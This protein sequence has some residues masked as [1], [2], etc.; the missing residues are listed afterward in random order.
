MSN[1]EIIS[2]GE[3]YTK[4]SRAKGI[5]I[6]GK[7]LLKMRNAF[8]IIAVRGLINKVLDLKPKPELLRLQ[9]KV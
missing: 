5:F 7:T 2:N 1:S 3:R 8:Y 9:I 4:R 6:R